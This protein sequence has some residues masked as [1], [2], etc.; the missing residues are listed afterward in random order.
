M[1]F[2]P[3]ALR[4][5]YECL[6]SFPKNDGRRELTRQKKSE[7]IQAIFT[8][9]V[10]LSS[11]YTACHFQEHSVTIFREHRINDG[12][13]QQVNFGKPYRVFVF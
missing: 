12:L 6:L 9:S 3:M 4:M 13:C 10:K 7:E 5:I 2:L 8:Q 1:E 11:F